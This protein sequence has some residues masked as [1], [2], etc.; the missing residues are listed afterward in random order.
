MS[1][2]EGGYPDEQAAGAQ[3]SIEEETSMSGAG[4]GTGG[5]SQTPHSPETGEGGETGGNDGGDP[6]EGDGASIN[7]GTG[8]SGDVPCSPRDPY[9]QPF[10]VDSIWNMPIHH[11][12]IYVDAGLGAPR[13]WGVTID[14]ENI[15]LEP[16]APLVNIYKNGW[17]KEARCSNENGFMTQAPIPDGWMFGAYT[18]N[19][20]A[21]VLDSDGVSLRQFQSLHRCGTTG[22]AYALVEY[23]A[24]HIAGDG[25]EG[26]HGGSGMSAIGGSIRIGDMVPEGDIFNDSEIYL[27]HALKINVFA[28]RY[29]LNVLDA[30]PGYRWPAVKADGYALRD[31]EYDGHIPEMEIGA[32]LALPDDIDPETMG[33][34]TAP[35]KLIARTMKRYGAYIVDDTAWDVVGL[36]IQVGPYGDVRDEFLDFYGFSM[37]PQSRDEPWAKDI[38][39]IVEALHVVDNNSA[40]SIGG[41]PTSDLENRLAPPACELGPI[42]SR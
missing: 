42:P 30:T 25:I 1:S 32:L 17:A 9:L 41:G 33:L 16:N 3:D 36:S 23:P 37:T 20:C 6:A 15:I 4:I 38:A 40:A 18:G 19:G 8:G 31:G 21:S 34:E 2:S 12:A 13:S 26:A 14:E 35:G 7:E 29:L 24:E 39:R 5:A 28:K 27:H 10:A 22:D 11:D